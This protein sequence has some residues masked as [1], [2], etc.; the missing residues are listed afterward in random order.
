MGNI[1]QAPKI[2]A[3]LERYKHFIDEIEDYRFQGPDG[4]GYWVHLKKG[5]INTH[6]EI[7]SVHEDNITRCA[8]VFK[9]G[10]IHPCACS[11]CTTKT[12]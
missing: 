11:Q 5:Y 3:S 4:D 10:A 8:E 1:S 2:P 12:E 7:H 6:D 9:A